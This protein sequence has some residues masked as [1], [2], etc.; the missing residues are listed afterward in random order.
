MLGILAGGDCRAM[1]FV[2]HGSGGVQTSGI[3]IT[4]ICPINGNDVCAVLE[5][6]GLD[7][8]RCAWAR[9]TLG[10]KQLDPIDREPALV[11]A[12]DTF[13]AGTMEVYDDGV[14]TGDLNISIETK[15]CQILLL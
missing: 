12:G 8:L 3:D 7:I 2:F 1:K 5:C 11:G 4:A 6:H 14:K 15:T 13:E 9:L 10:S